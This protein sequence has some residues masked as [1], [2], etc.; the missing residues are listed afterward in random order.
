MDERLAAIALAIG[1]LTIALNILQ[2]WCLHKHF[3]RHVNPLMVIIFHLS[4]ADLVQGMLAIVTFVI[5]L[6]ERKVFIGSHIL[7]QCIDVCVEANK[8]LQS[9]SIVTLATLTVLK[10]LRVTQNEWLTKSTIKRIC[11]RIWIVVSVCFLAEFVVYKVHGYSTDAALVSSYR[12]LRR[13]LLALPATILLMFCFAKIFYR[14]RIR[15]V[16]TSLEP[17]GR[18]RRFLIISILNLVTFMVC[19]APLSVLDIVDVL[20]Q[21]PGKVTNL[22]KVFVLFL[23]LNPLVDSV[24]FLIVYRRELRGHRPRSR[25]VGL[26]TSYPVRLRD[27]QF[28][29]DPVLAHRR[30]GNETCTGI[31]FVC[32]STSTV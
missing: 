2:L 27:I 22:Q 6:L 3:R 24:G 12:R 14:L 23:M 16:R 28:R 8:Y 4:A 29:H 1:V 26:R 20:L 19:V 9:V 17:V 30:N 7:H 11:R 25:E 13:P 18:R 5:I 10:M 21:N 15:Q 31:A 32:H